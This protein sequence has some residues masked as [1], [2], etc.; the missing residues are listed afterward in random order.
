MATVVG[1]SNQIDS[2]TLSGGSWNASYPLN[3]LKTRYLNQKARSSNALTSSTQ[4]VIDRGSAVAVNVVAIVNH[5]LTANSATVQVQA[6]SVSN[7][8]SIIYDTGALTVYGIADDF[9]VAIPATTARYWK[10]SIAD[11]GN[12]AGY[13]E[14]GRVFI[15]PSIPQFTYVDWGASIGVE[16]DTQVVKTLGGPEFF[17]SGPR[18][19][20]WRGKFSYID[21][22][23]AYATILAHMRRYYLDTSH[24]IYFIEDDTDLTT[25]RKVRNFLGR[26]RVLNPIEWPYHDS[27]SIAVEI[28]ELL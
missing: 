2:C 15:G 8:A 18:R 22:N 23:T 13:V 28:S 27:H 21:D 6:S 3:N 17:D 11:T 19:L 1:Y 16:T 20:V 24:E 10:V 14:I 9:S 4:V 25:N 12:S 5:N 7:F 26:M